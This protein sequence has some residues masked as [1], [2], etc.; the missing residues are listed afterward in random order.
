[1]D[2]QK[3]PLGFQICLFSLLL[4]E[5]DALRERIQAVHEFQLRISTQ[6]EHLVV[7]L[8]LV[9]DHVKSGH[10]LVEPLFAQVLKASLECVPLCGDLVQLSHALQVQL[11]LKTHS[12]TC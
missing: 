7:F 6:C 8:Q 2:Q 3:L 4:P 1:M 12:S 5:H 9:C 10:E 11:L